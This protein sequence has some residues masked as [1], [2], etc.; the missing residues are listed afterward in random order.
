MTAGE[1]ECM[2]AL[3]CHSPPAVRRVGTKWQKLSWFIHSPFD[4]G[5]LEVQIELILSH[6]SKNRVVSPATP[7]NHE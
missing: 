4:N 7:P 5:V 2:R 6:L 1:G 3:R